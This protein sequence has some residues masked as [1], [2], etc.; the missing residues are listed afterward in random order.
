MQVP[1]NFEDAAR[2]TGSLTMSII[3]AV[4]RAGQKPEDT[5]PALREASAYAHTLARFLDRL[6]DSLAGELPA[7]PPNVTPIIRVS[8]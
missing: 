5:I 3:D 6:G 1:V 4:G 2:L 7:N 8:P